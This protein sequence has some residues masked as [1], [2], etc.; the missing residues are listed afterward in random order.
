[1]TESFTY[2]LTAGGHANSLGRVNEVIEIVLHEKSRIGELYDCLFNKDAWVRMRAADALE[3]ICRQQ[4]DWLLPYIDK[5]QKEVSA[6]TQA[7]V[8]WHLAQIYAQV[9]LTDVQKQAAQDWL[10]GLLSTKEVDWIVAANAMDTLVKFTKD[11]SFPIA[12][13]TRLLKIQQ[14]HMSNAVV[15]RA[16]KY[17][18]EIQA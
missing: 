14:Q 9:A 8:R 12:K 2:V 5:F 3:K 11:G 10:V 18:V 15:K 4:P 13:M 6:S 16:T 7:S 17:L 1:V